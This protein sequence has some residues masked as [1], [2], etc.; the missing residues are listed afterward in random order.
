MEM[1]SA[2]V[3]FICIFLMSKAVFGWIRGV[4]KLRH[5][6]GPPGWPLIGNAYQMDY[7]YPY[8][9]FTEWSKSYGN[10]FRVTVFGKD[11]VILSD[12]EAI[13]EML[14][15][16][17]CSSRRQSHR[18]QNLALK[19]WREITF[20]DFSAE[21]NERKKALNRSLNAYGSG[22]MQIEDV[23][24][25]CIDK[26]FDNIVKSSN[27][28]TQSIDLRPAL[29]MCN[30]GIITNLFYGKEVEESE[31][32][33]LSETGRG[34]LK[35]ITASGPYMFLDL[36][37]WICN[38]P[39]NSIQ[40]T[41]SEG[42][43]MSEWIEKAHLDSTIQNGVNDRPCILNS[44]QQFVNKVTNK[45]LQT[46]EILGMAHN[47]VVGGFI[48]STAFLYSL[49]LVLVNFPDIQEKMY[50]EIKRVTNGMRPKVTDRPKMTYIKAVM[51]EN[52]RFATILP[53]GVP[54]LTSQDFTISGKH[55]PK[56]TGIFA[57]YWL[58]HHDEQF[59]DDPWEFKPERFL[60][61]NGQMIGIDNPIWKHT[62]PF[63]GGLRICPGE[64]LARTRMF[65][66]VASL[67]QKFQF[68]PD[69]DTNIPS[70]DPRGSDYQG[71]IIPKAYKVKLVKR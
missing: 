19:G 16:K 7:S 28:Y 25:L 57:N 24:Q 61:D 38:L 36:F 8:K 59:F 9:R 11:I 29:H 5:I 56:G 66:I 20:Q 42:Q 1:F 30:A 67:L 31:L 69:D 27:E 15:S 68:L 43:K 13:H 52:F 50:Q 14:T 47:I 37:P 65:L 18:A 34:L 60:A 40:R 62:K 64:I 17:A 44:L 2:I 45:H 4:R 22:L 49:F 48:T 63:S 53:L 26:L 39:I 21:W 10:I 54:H 3:A 55:I 46:D 12:P 58:L 51:E 6:P 32:L 23:S 70:C 35:L 33:K 41:I 71:V